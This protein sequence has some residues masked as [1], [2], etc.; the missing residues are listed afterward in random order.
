MAS[1]RLTFR[2][3]ESSI[4]PDYG[5]LVCRSFECLHNRTR[6]VKPSPCANLIGDILSIVFFSNLVSWSQAFQNDWY[7]HSIRFI[8]T[9]AN[10]YTSRQYDSS[11]PTARTTETLS[12]WLI[13]QITLYDILIAQWQWLLFVSLQLL[14][15][16]MVSAKTSNYGDLSVRLNVCFFFLWLSCLMHHIFIRIKKPTTTNT[17]DNKSNECSRWRAR[18]GKHKGSSE[19]ERAKINLMAF[20][21]IIIIT[22]RVQFHGL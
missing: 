18:R 16:Y 21:P 3:P 22:K 4:S 7:E 15:R 14:L 13:Q 20:L 11:I 9:D 5:L 17:S 1:I 19:T 2:F 10:Q 12:N 6:K 8:I